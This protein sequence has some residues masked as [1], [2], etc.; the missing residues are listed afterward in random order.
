M[1]VKKKMNNRV[2]FERYMERWNEKFPGTNMDN[3]VKDENI[4]KF[5]YNYHG[6]ASRKDIWHQ[7]NLTR[8]EI[9]NRCD[10]LYK[11]GFITKRIEQSPSYR[12]LLHKI[13]PLSKI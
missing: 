8:D 7:M 10:E 1:E 2:K 6:W 11:R 9:S 5:L 12:K 4:L 13:Q 3:M